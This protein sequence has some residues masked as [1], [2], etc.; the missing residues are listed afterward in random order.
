[1]DQQYITLGVALLGFITTGV[2]VWINSKTNIKIAKDKLESDE[3]Q[4]QLKIKLDLKKTLY[5]EYCE[6]ISKMHTH[7]IK[8]INEPENRTNNDVVNDFLACTNKIKLVADSKIVIKIIETERNYFLLYTHIM[9]QVFTFAN[10]EISYENKTNIQARLE[11]ELDE[12]KNLLKKTDDKNYALYLER[13]EEFI[14]KSDH[15]VDFIN[16]NIELYSTIFNSR[17]QLMKDCYMRIDTLESLNEELI[18]LMREDIGL[19]NDRELFDYFANSNSEDLK[20]AISDLLDSA[21]PE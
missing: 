17:K 4:N 19:E 10:K 20:N 2:T 14:K 16:Q 5:L 15:L 1:M 21:I 3:K 7:L 9:K 6:Y 8:I 11:A 12:I 13:S 18:L